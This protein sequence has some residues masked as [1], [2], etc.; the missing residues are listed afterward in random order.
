MRYFILLFSF[1]IVSA[2]QQNIYAQLKI[3]TGSCK[4]SILLFQA[5]SIRQGLSELGFK[6][7][8]EWFISME[9]QYEQPIYLPLQKGLFYHIVFIGE[10][11]SRRRELSFYDGENRKLLGDV[12]GIREDNVIRF[13]HV[14][15]TTE[16]F[17]AT[18]LQVNS[19]KKDICGHL[20]IFKKIR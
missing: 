16:Y 4:D 13:G 7:A 20:M 1:I 3:A 11:S 10:Q 19:K 17:T 5:D 2:T 18:L 14:P 12:K 8:A 9:S 15:Q 6:F